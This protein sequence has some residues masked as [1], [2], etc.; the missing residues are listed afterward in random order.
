MYRG[1]T[2]TDISSPNIT[3]ENI[4]FESFGYRA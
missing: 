4:T 3:L 2:V 1:R